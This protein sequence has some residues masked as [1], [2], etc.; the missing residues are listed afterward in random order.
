MLKK[1]ITVL[2][3]SILLVAFSHKAHAFVQGEWNMN[4][5]EK[6]SAKVK[7]VA[8]SKY[9]DDFSDTWSFSADGQFAIDGMPLG[10]WGIM[11]KKF[12][13]YID[14][15][16][17]NIILA[18]NLQD[19]GFPGDTAV[20][21]TSTKASG[22]ITKAGSIK[23]TYKVVAL[24]TTSGVTGKMTV[25]GNF[26][27]TKISDGDN[28]P[29][30]GTTFTISEYFPLGQGDT[31]TYREE[32][33]ELTV[34][35]ISGTEN[36]NGVDAAKIMDEDGD[37]YLWTNSNGLVWHKEYDADDVPGCG[38]QQLI[39]NPPIIASGAVVS[40]GST[41]SSNTILGETD[42]AGGSATASI[43]YVFNVEGID[44]VT[45]P[46]GTFNNCLRIKGILTVN[47]STATNEMTIWL[48]KG[49]GEVKSI[50]VSKQN[51]VAVATWTDEL[52]SAVVGGVSF[53]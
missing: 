2:T 16:V 23:G 24:V 8:T 38:W 47:G 13:V 27:G 39:F 45:V 46:A 3:A 53:N 40:V 5:I 34:K 11:K 41:Y 52:V 15:S 51:G 44:S 28:P 32:D 35:T 50:S 36:I 26:S 14:A 30:D 18:N 33:D 43:S 48:A 31:W 10:T 21:I 29:A 49:V 20:T 9:T 22:T 42:C 1:L 12:V 7:K 37:Y 17:L 4:V 25:N 19:A 6:I